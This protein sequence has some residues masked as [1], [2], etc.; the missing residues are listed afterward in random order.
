M[1]SEVT[2]CVRLGV[3]SEKFRQKNRYQQNIVSEQFQTR[4]LSQQNVRDAGIWNEFR[5]W[6][7]FS[8]QNETWAKLSTLEG[9]ARYSCVYCRAKQ[10]GLS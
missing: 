5:A 2:L 1:S 4:G 8:L 9:D 3:I 10:Y 6:T 7:D